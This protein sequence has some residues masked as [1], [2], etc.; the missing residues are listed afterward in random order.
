MGELEDPFRSAEALEAV[1]A[2][3]T[4]PGAVRKLVDDE[5]GRGGREQHLAA[6]AHPHE[7]GR[8][9]DRRPVVIPGARLSHSTVDPHPHAQGAGLA[10]RLATEALLRVEA[11]AHSVGSGPEDGHESV[12]RPLD[13]LPIEGLDR[14]GDDRIVTLQGSLHGRRELLP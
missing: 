4:E 2:E 5:R 10:P 12:P 11:G 9:V 8:T 3:I 7:P 1:V 13:H 14:G 6:V